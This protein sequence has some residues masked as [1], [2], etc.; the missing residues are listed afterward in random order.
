M[1]DTK[2][3]TLTLFDN[4]ANYAHPVRLLVIN[5]T[6]PSEMDMLLSADG[7][8][9][10]RVLSPMVPP[11]VLSQKTA[12][13]ENEIRLLRGKLLGENYRDLNNDEAVSKFKRLTKGNP[14]LV[15]LGFD[16]L[17]RGRPL[18]FMTPHS[19][20]EERV[21]RILEALKTAG[22]GNM[23]L[24]LAV[25]TLAGG[26]DTDNTGVAGKNLQAL[27][28]FDAVDLDR[29]S[30]IFPERRRVVLDQI[31]QIKPEL[32]GSAF[33]KVVMKRNKGHAFLVAEAAW[34]ENPSG[35]LR[36]VL[37]F[38]LDQ[39]GKGD[40]CIGDFLSARPPAGIQIPALDLFKAYAQSSCLCIREDW[41]GGAYGVGRGL[42][43][44]ATEF[45]VEFTT[46]ESLSALDFVFRLAES[47]DDFSIKR[48]DAFDSII[49]CLLDGLLAHDSTEVLSAVIYGLEKWVTISPERS[50]GYFEKKK[51]R[52]GS[53]S[54]A[55][56]SLKGIL[57]SLIG[58]LDHN[59]GSRIA[60]LFATEVTQK[61]SQNASIS[62]SAEGIA[63]NLIAR[64][65]QAALLN[66]AGN[67]EALLD[68]AK[69]MQTSPLNEARVLFAIA[70]TQVHDSAATEEIVEK[71]I[72]NT[73][74]ISR[75]RRV[76]YLRMQAWLLL[77][78]VDT[79]R[80]KVR[81]TDRMV[82]NVL[83]TASRWKGDYRFDCARAKSLRIAAAANTSASVA[84][85]NAAERVDEIAERFSTDRRLELE[86]I[87]AW[88][89]VMHSH[90]YDGGRAAALVVGHRIDKLA[91]P[92]IGDIT[93][94]YERALTWKELA[95][96]NRGDHAAVQLAVSRVD[97]IAAPFSGSRHF[98]FVRAEAWLC[99]AHCD[100]SSIANSLLAVRKIE[101]IAAQ[102]G[103][104]R[105][106]DLLRMTAW[107][108]LAFFPAS[109]LM[110]IESVVKQVEEIGAPYAGETKYDLERVRAWWY[111][112]KDNQHDLGVV[113]HAVRQVDAIVSLHQGAPDFAIDHAI[114]W[115][116]ITRGS[117]KQK[118]WREV[119]DSIVKMEA[120]AEPLEGCADIALVLADVFE[121]VAALTAS[122]KPAPHVLA[123]SKFMAISAR[124]NGDPRFDVLRERANRWL[125][126]FQST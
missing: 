33:V 95:E 16:W 116:I 63:A 7:V 92:F 65:E 8:W 6:A 31:P 112:A 69:S 85:R 4:R 91:S 88:R 42:E 70:K 1:N 93:F 13:Q 10:S 100:N 106:F 59:M 12:F 19:L 57:D 97:E 82:Q 2:Q 96:S 90:L 111:L 67:V 47:S 18:S 109:D 62:T 25:A 58:M 84:A 14:L 64:A 20:L 104:D 36:S 123:A 5:Q 89:C 45:I 15:E 77:A 125:L 81:Q 27:S 76:D 105:E 75:D 35:M 107:R 22:C 51:P 46:K 50:Y 114:A 83:E 78:P 110:C 74:S 79:A 103:K 126:E 113:R 44:T 43:R 48:W 3:V 52:V 40:E 21:E 30:R 29:L 102:F 118:L 117:A 101:T 49:F 60:R 108:F 86:R 80:P 32:I 41:L 54:L 39:V 53:V 11:I 87:K 66:N 120:A 37:L 122:S 24:A 98:E 99:L 124:F 68:E 71:I 115:G 61:I 121:N 28:G 9:D 26:A 38:D 23:A 94:E 72:A 17:K 34:T 56:T 73:A 55:S 119:E